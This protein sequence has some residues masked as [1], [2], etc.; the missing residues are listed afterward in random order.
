MHN[1][2]PPIFRIRSILIIAFFIVL[3]VSAFVDIIKNKFKKDYKVIWLIVVIFIPILGAIYYFIIGR[4]QKII[5][6]PQITK[7]KR[8][9]NP[10]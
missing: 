1:G 10:K 3:W 4:K 9:S 5:K 2:M 6:K 8:T 7:Y